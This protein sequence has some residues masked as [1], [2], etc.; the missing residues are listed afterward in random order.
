MAVALGARLAARDHGRWTAYAQDPAN[1][2]YEPFPSPC[3]SPLSS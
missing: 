3:N 1:N 2:T